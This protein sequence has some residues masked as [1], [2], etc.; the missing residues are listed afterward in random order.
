MKA[1]ILSDTHS[2]PDDRGLLQLRALRPDAILHAGDVGD[3]GVIARLG[4]IAPVHAVRGNI[5][6]LTPELPDERSVMLGNLTVFMTHI[7][8]YR[9]IRVR[10][11]V[12]RKAAAAKAQ[13][14][15]CGHSHVPFITSEGGILLF[16][17]G[18]M[19]PRRENLPILYGVLEV[20][21]QGIS[22]KHIDV[23]TGMTWLPPALNA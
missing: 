2:K 21:P 19:G 8:V 4:S 15:V 22:L 7:A 16:N 14:I 17:P 6:A 18:S 20:G 9:G 13:L 12:L 5:D 1:A 11:D 10:K 23:T 3:V